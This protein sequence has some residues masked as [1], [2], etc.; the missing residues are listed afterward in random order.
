MTGHV[1]WMR[2]TAGLASALLVGAVWAQ[3]AGDQ[4]SGEVKKIDKGAQ[5]ITL[6]HGDIKTL[7]MPAMT[8]VFKAADPQLLDKVKVGDKVLFNAERRDGALVVTTLQTAP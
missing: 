7:D 1:F 6:K 3:A 5:K 4:A 2:C 8:M